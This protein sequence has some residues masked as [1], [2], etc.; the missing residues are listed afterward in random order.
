MGGD[1]QALDRFLNPLEGVPHNL[2]MRNGK[3]V[4]MNPNIFVQNK[5]KGAIC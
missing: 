2:Y 5:W 4:S 1:G 3:E